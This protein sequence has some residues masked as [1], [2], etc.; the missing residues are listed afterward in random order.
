M[1][2][3]QDSM[4]TRH[5]NSLARRDW[6]HSAGSAF[7]ALALSPASSWAAPNNA[8]S[9]PRLNVSLNENPFGPSPRVAQALRLELRG[10]E[11]YTDA[12]ASALSRQI[13]Q[14]EQV[15]PEQVILGEILEPLGVQLGL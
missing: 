9:R 11:R 15:E 13:A 5:A 7:V 4:T 1:T 8:A 14:L 3:G 10:L 2:Q 6:L 12:E